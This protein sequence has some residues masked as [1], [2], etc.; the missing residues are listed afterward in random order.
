MIKVGLCGWTIGQR[1]YFERFPVLE[2]QQTFYDPPAERVMLRWREAAPAGFEFTM[3]AWQLITHDASSRTYARMRRPLDR[4][5]AGSF[6]ATE[7]VEHGWDVTLRCARILRA[8]A[9]LFQCPRSFKPTAENLDNL[10]RFFANRERH[11]LRFLWEPR[12]AWPPEVVCALCT[13]LELV[14]VVDPFVD[15]RV[16]EAIYFRLHGT[17]GSRHVYTD[18]ELARVAE[19]VQGADDAYVMFN[20][21]P[22]VG[23]AERFMKLLR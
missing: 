21:I 19:L 3:K 10:R 9:V 8:T 20:N 18:A 23:D 12:G 1:H 22:R 2:V 5:G 17:T 4:N 13:D 16:T 11:G 15:T 7:I 6:R 14:H